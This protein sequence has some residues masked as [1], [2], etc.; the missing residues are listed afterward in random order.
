MFD[1]VHFV[2]SYTNPSQ[3]TIREPSDSQFTIPFVVAQRSCYGDGFNQL[4]VIPI[5]AY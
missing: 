5:Q 3:N 2:T 4:I 1:K